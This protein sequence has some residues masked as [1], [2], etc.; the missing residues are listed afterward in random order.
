MI[1]LCK[2][3]DTIHFIGVPIAFLCLLEIA[4][5]IVLYLINMTVEVVIGINTEGKRDILAIEPMI[6]ES[7]TTYRSPFMILKPEA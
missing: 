3:L 7:E 6:E 4:N 1:L 2:C 5:F